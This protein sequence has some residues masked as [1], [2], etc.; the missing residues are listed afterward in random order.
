MPVDALG[1]VY[2]GLVAAGG[3]FGMYLPT[4]CNHQKLLI[5]IIDNDFLK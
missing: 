5:V 1:Y 4:F 3:I 2:A